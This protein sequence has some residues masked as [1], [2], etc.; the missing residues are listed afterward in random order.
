MMGNTFSLSALLLTLTACNGFGDERL[1][2]AAAWFMCGPADGPVTAIVLAREPVQLN[3]PS[4]PLVSIQ[5]FEGV[6]TLA[7]RTWNLTGDSAHAD[8]VTQLHSEAVSS[9][10][11][12]ITG[13][14]GAKTVRGKLSATFG[15]RA[16]V[17]DFAAPWLENRVL[18]G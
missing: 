9:G 16:V 5:I 3:H 15:G 12:T 8:Y 18:C 7:G 11:V 6:S 13:V 14:D 4:Y 10:T 2:H 17:T 1:S